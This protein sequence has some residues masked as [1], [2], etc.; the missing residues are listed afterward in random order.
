MIHRERDDL[1]PFARED[2]QRPVVRRALDEDAA[3]PALEGLGRVEHE[4]QQPADGQH[5]P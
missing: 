2:L 3:G 1:D 4:A 5:D